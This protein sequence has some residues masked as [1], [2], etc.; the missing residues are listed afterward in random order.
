MLLPSNFPS[1]L[2]LPVT[3]MFSGFNVS[4]SCREFLTNESPSH[5]SSV[6][7]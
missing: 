3:F 2:Y 7:N 5:P 1:Y 6:V 4:I